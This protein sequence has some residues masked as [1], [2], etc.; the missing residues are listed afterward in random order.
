FVPAAQKVRLLHASVRHHLRREGRWDEAALGVPICQEDMIG[1]QMIFSILVLDALHRLGVHITEDEADA[2]FHAWQ[3][4]G[5]M[6]GVDA[7]QA[8]ATLA[9]ARDFCDLYMTHYMGPSEPG[10]LLTRQLI[11]LYQDVVP[12]ALLD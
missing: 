7:S 12:G 4:V 6:L 5:A 3:V 2:Y 8:P 10:V 1:G 11:D 9:E